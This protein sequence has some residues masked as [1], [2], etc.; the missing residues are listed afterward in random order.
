MFKLM[1]HFEFVL[2][3]VRNVSHGSFSHMHVQLFQ[4]HCTKTGTFADN[5]R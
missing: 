5:L 2:Y 1:I 4:H 3:V